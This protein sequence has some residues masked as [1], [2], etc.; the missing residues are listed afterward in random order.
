M[1]TG[2]F[3]RLQALAAR[4]LGER[5]DAQIGGQNLAQLRHSPFLKRKIAVSQLPAPALGRSP[6]FPSAFLTAATDRLGLGNPEQGIGDCAAFRLEVRSL[7]ASMA[8]NFATLAQ[9]FESRAQKYGA[10]TF[11][12]DKSNKTWRDHSWAAIAD[13][14]A[15]LRAGLQKMGIQ[16]GDRVGILSDNSPQWV[17]V[18]QAV[19]GLG[20]I[21]VPLYTTSGA[22]E[23]RHVI[24]D[25]G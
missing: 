23:T 21:V 25:S 16:P 8:E 18:D 19:L 2:V 24:S 4:G 12:K 15:R 11:L 9:A 5:M 17:I 6:D 7:G 3:Q 14:A 10:R 22:E 20:G 1:T 13:A